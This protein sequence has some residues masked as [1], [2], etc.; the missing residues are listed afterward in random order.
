MKKSHRNLIRL[1]VL[2][3]TACLLYECLIIHPFEET[4][5]EIEQAETD[6]IMEHGFLELDNIGQGYVG[7]GYANTEWPGVILWRK[8]DLIVI[9][10][11]VLVESFPAD[12]PS[13]RQIAELRIGEEVIFG[14][15]R[16][17]VLDIY[18]VRLT[19]FQ[20]DY[21]VILAISPDETS[22]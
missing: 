20:G 22:R 21:K 4:S 13:S 12:G 18:W 9:L 16:V 11:M 7:I 14:G 19:L 10:E 1:L 5:M 2:S 6:W 3:L 8:Q 17:K 15:Y